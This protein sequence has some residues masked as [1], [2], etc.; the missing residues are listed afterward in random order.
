MRVRVTRMA[1]TTEEFTAFTREDIVYDDGCVECSPHESDEPLAFVNR[2]DPEYVIHESCLY[3]LHPRQRNFYIAIKDV[4]SG[5]LTAAEKVDA[6]I[7]DSM[8][9]DEDDEEYELDEA[10]EIHLTN[11]DTEVRVYPPGVETI[12]VPPG[13]EVIS[14]EFGRKQ[15]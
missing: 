12:E 7:G 10:V 3:K 2:E 5:K 4:P 8:D 9:A 11:E 15:D 1:A 14:V 13:M 6:M